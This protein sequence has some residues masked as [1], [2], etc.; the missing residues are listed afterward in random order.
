MYLPSCP[1]CGTLIRTLALAA[2][3]SCVAALTN[4]ARAEGPLDTARVIKHLPRTE[5][6]VAAAHERSRGYACEL[7][8]A[9]ESLEISD[10]I[11]ERNADALAGANAIPLV[12]ARRAF[13][14][15]GLELLPDDRANLPTLTGGQIT[16][17]L[18]KHYVCVSTRVQR[19]LDTGE[20][21]LGH[22]PLAAT[23]TF[24]G[25]RLSQAFDELVSD[26][27]RDMRSLG[28]LIDDQQKLT[29]AALRTLVLLHR[30]QR[31]ADNP[32]VISKPK[33]IYEYIFLRGTP[34]N[35]RSGSDALTLTT[36]V[37]TE[38]RQRLHMLRPFAFPRRLEDCGI[39]SAVYFTEFKLANQIP[40]ASAVRKVI[41]NASISFKLDELEQY[42]K[43]QG[44]LGGTW[45]HVP[46]LLD[47]I[48]HR[49]LT[50]S[51]G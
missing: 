9:G 11:P 12:S 49:K 2:A 5:T 40:A 37:T 17:Y 31:G 33:P 1:Y 13:L 27:I 51:G 19:D 30:S 23:A 18:D 7:L 6:E 10:F 29:P 43:Q 8:G 32:Q 14:S 48:I 3:F 4:V 42:L 47:A 22:R 34:A 45:D 44:K 46:E 38:Q 39:R 16:D 24:R 20:L 25:V 35:G 41:P 28:L 15:A 26:S 21:Y 36:F 50:P